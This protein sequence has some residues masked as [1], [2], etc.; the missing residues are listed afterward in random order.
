MHFLMKYSFLGV[1][2]LAFAT[3]F[4]FKNNFTEIEKVIEETRVERTKKLSESFRKSINSEVLSSAFNNDISTVNNDV[5]SFE[6]E[7]CDFENE[8]E[9]N[10]VYSYK[11]D[12][13]KA[14]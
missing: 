1:I 5:D 2:A 6:S 8:E 14:A 9:L 3:F 11:T 13:S 7:D 12:S 10:S 4:R